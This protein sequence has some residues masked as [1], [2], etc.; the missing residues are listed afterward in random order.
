VQPGAPA[1]G[2]VK[3]LHRL[4]RNAVRQAAPVAGLDQ[5][6]PDGCVGTLARWPYIG[7]FDDDPAFTNVI[8]GGFVSSTAATQT[9]AGRT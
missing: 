2:Q 5:P 8:P 7:R 3:R 1:A 4:I 9:M 6:R